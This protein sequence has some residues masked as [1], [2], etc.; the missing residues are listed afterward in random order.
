MEDLGFGP[1]LIIRKASELIEKRIR[2]AI[3]DGKLKSGDRLSTE[4]KMA[5]QFGVSLVTIREALKAL[6]VTGMIEK[7]KG[8]G[9]GVFISTIGNKSI[10]DSLGHFLR[11]KDLSPQHV[12]QVRKI[13]E[14][15][16]IKLAASKITPDE[17][18][19]L[20]EN[21]S[22]CGEKLRNAGPLFTEKDFFDVDDLCID[23]HR[24]IAESAGN[25]LL[26][27]VVDYVLDF[28]VEYERKILVP[29]LKY[30]LDCKGS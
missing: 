16:S 19:R 10:K 8:Q 13:I 9:G 21:V 18:E 7:R 28:L 23:F 25:P 27:L 20:E 14:P 4:K 1:P 22:Y 5:E 11:L 29:D 6:E 24:I 2:D 12:Y 3:L 15:P 30:S 17:L 26:S